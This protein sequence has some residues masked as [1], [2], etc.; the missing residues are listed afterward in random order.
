MASPEQASCIRL[1]QSDPFKIGN[2]Y[3]GIPVNLVTNLICWA[4]LIV[5]FLVVR[6]STIRN[7][8]RKAGFRIRIQSGHWIRIR[9]RIRNPDPDPGGQKLPT[10]VEKI[11][12]FHVLKWCMFF[13]ED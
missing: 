10:K 4:I 11:K 12:T 7:V 5:F 8:G 6:K 3:G 2:N 13:F 1:N 9:F